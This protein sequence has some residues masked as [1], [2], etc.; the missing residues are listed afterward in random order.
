M[1]SRKT[2][3]ALRALTYLVNNQNGRVSA[4]QMSGKIKVSKVFLAKI[5]QTLAERGF[6]E[7]QRGKGGGVKLK[8]DKAKLSEI[9]FAFE[10]Q[11]ALNRCLMKGHTCF[12]EK[13]CKLHDVFAGLQNEMFEKLGRLSISDLKERG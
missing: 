8:N 12:L 2:D 1:I 4:A 10:P 3:Y 5:F 7:T 13:E 9:I 11:F 6:V